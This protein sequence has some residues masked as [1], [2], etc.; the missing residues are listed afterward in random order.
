MLKKSNVH[1][2][3]D[4]NQQLLYYLRNRESCGFNK[5]F[6]KKSCINLSLLLSLSANRYSATTPKINE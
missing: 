6:E 3:H 2:I 5:Y 4:T 1:Q